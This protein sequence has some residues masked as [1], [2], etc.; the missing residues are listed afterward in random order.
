MNLSLLPATPDQYSAIYGVMALAGEHMHR[1]LRLSHWHPFPSSDWFIQQCEE[2]EVFAVYQDSLLIGTFNIGSM[3]EKYYF[4]D[5]S[6][7]WKNP[8]APT[9]YFSA[10]AL[11]PSHQQQGVGSWCMQQVDRLVMERGH[12]LVRF[13]AVSHHEK[14]LHFYDRLGYERR[15]VLDLG[16]V[17]VMCYEKELPG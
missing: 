15:G 16:H 8:A 2:R 10:F 7:Y 9:L 17:A 3:P 14:L 12:N 11:L 13:D 6:A 5:M 4:A 1:V